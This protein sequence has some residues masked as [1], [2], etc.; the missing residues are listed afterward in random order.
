MVEM[1]KDKEDKHRVRRWYVAKGID[2]DDTTGKQD[3]DSRDMDTDQQ[4]QQARAKASDVQMAGA[5]SSSAG[6]AGIAQQGTD[7]DKRDRAELEDPGGKKHKT[8]D[9][10]WEDLAKRIK[11][12]CLNLCDT[13]VN[14]DRDKHDILNKFIDRNPIFT[15]TSAIQPETI[16]H[17][18]R[19]QQH[20]NMKY[21]IEVNGKEITTNSTLTLSMLKVK[22]IIKEFKVKD[23]CCSALVR[24]DADGKAV[25]TAINQG[26]KMQMEAD[27]K[28]LFVCEVN[29][30]DLNDESIVEAKESAD[31]CHEAEDHAHM[32]TTT[33]HMTTNDD[34]GSTLRNG[35]SSEG[36]VNDDFAWDDVNNCQLDASRVREARKAEM[37]YFKKM[38]VYKKV[39]IQRCKDLTGKMPIKVRWI[40]TNKQDEANPKYRS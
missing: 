37:D 1:E 9:K 10:S 11:V 6:A 30:S 28:Q 29:G 18:L 39:P 15:I 16:R 12:K 17:E 26:M 2:T 3:D 38:Q 33:N 24:D 7:V 27:Q 5:S 19:K 22:G 23:G 8:T 35:E 36:R 21:F 40:D 31:R 25:E 34:A 20:D 32:T 4:G 14:D 13:N